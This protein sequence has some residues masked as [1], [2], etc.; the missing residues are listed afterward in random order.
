MPDTTDVVGTWLRKADL[1]VQTEALL[2]VAQEQAIRN[3]SVKHH[4]DKTAESPLCRLCG[5]NVDH[6][7]SGFK[8]LAQKEYKKYFNQKK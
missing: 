5:E 7:V 3:N 2:C 6:I 4:I 8:K 1:K